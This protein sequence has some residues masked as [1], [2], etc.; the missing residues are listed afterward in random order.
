MSSL[1]PE[2]YERA[3]EELIEA[4]RKAAFTQARLAEPPAG[5]NYSSPNMRAAGVVDVAEYLKIA[6]ALGAAPT[7]SSEPLRRAGIKGASPCEAV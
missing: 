2:L 7:N 4:R 1:F 6:R 5:H 3:L